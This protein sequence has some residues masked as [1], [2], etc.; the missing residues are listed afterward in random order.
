IPP[1]LPG[2]YSGPVYADKKD[3]NDNLC[4]TAHPDC[5]RIYFRPGTANGLQACQ[6]PACPPAGVAP[7]ALGGF[8]ISGA[9][10]VFYQ[11][12]AE[13]QSDDTVVLWEQHV[14]NPT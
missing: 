10:K 2:N 4:T 7:S 5:L 13:I 11:A 1:S 3:K 6:Q 9:D 12:H 8:E 14:T